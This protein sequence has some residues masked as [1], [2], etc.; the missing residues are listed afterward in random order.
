VSIQ[1]LAALRGRGFAA[2]FTLAAPQAKDGPTDIFFARIGPED[3]A[4]RKSS[5]ARN[6]VKTV[7]EPRTADWGALRVASAAAVRGSGAVDSPT[8]I[9][10][11]HSAP[12]KDRRLPTV[13]GHSPWPPQRIPGLWP[14]ASDL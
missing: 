9:A 1:G 5:G 14:K 6:A 8:P 11:H 7:T 2:I 13:W 4:D 10:R 3:K 12:D